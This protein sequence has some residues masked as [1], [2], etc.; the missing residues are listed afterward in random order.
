MTEIFKNIDS[1][2]MINREID[3]DPK[4]KSAKSKASYK[5]AL[6]QFNKWRAGRGMTKSLIEEY[7]CYQLSEG[8]KQNSIIRMRS[9]IRWWAKRMIVLAYDDNSLTDED[10]Q[11]LIA[12]AEGVRSVQVVRGESKDSRPGRY[13]PL[14]EVEALIDCCQSDNSPIG[15]RDAAI[16][17]IFRATGIRRGEL[18]D[19]TPSDIKKNR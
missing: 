2:E 12:F 7:L 3:R 15:V 1:Q 11:E 18:L 5:L 14:V 16:F 4:L 8:Y 17:A 19:L 9:S 13:L 6:A 10:R